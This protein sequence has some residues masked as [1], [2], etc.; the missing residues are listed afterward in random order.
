MR[1]PNAFLAV[2]CSFSVAGA[3]EADVP[4]ALCARVEQAPT[5]DG[6]LDDAAWR[7]CEPLTPFV[8]LDGTGPANQQTEVRLCWDGSSLFL[9][10]ELL[11]SEMGKLQA[12]ETPPD[13]GQLFRNDC[14]E[15]FVQPDP[16]IG[17]YFHLVASAAGSTYDA[18][19][20]G[21]PIDWTPEWS[22]Q[23][24]R[25]TDRWFLE[26]A[27]LLGQIR[28]GEVREGQTIRFNVCREEKPHDEQRRV[29]ANSRH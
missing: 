8:K 5:V 22:V 14:V 10:C 6:R 3:Q 29:D 24:S 20:R 21:G 11:E 9:G 26:A 16:A 23:V 28:L 19:A 13:S 25:G 17:E 7:Q 27:V 4:V 1:T 12:E 18:I 2:V 15:I